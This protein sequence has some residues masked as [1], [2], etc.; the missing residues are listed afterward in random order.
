M[1]WQADTDYISVEKKLPQLG[2]WLRHELSQLQNGRVPHINFI[3]GNTTIPIGFSVELTQ[4][5]LDRSAYTATDVEDLLKIADFGPDYHPSHPASAGEA[6][7]SSNMTD[8]TNEKLSK[9]SNILGI[10][11]DAIVSQVR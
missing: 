3:F 11:R 5:S 10:D 1:Y 7:I 9:S 2:G 4:M 8:K 6:V